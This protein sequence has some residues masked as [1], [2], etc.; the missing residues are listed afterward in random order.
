MSNDTNIFDH[1]P[2]CERKTFFRT[3]SVYRCQVCFRFFC[4]KCCEKSFWFGY[5]KCPHCLVRIPA[6]KVLELKAGFC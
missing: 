3:I 1:C 2:R 4:D 6:D 5:K